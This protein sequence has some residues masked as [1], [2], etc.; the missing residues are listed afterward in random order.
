MYEPAM[1][2]WMSFSA[3]KMPIAWRVPWFLQGFQL[4]PDT[5][6]STWWYCSATN[7]S[8]LCCVWKIIDHW[9]WSMFS[10][11]VTHFDPFCCWLC[12]GVL[13]KKW[14]TRTILPYPALCSIEFVAKSVR[15]GIRA[16]VLVQTF[17][18]VQGAAQQLLTDWKKTREI[19]DGFDR[20]PLLMC[21]K[22]K[23]HGLVAAC[24]EMM[25]E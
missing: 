7:V 13:P 19:C 10:D 15:R 21:F 14:R 1:T 8:L 16:P 2:R 20:I 3:L 11:N 9:S 23:W 18:E 12:V 22:P 5:P 24:P 17:Y 25:N 4:Q 6:W